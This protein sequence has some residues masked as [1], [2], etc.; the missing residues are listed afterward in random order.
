MGGAEISEVE[1]EDFDENLAP[2]TARERRSRASFWATFESK[3]GVWQEVIIP[4]D[5]FWPN[6]RGR[7]LDYRPIEASKIREVGLMIYDG[8]DGPF[9]FD[10]KKI[11]II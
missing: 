8:D 11:E 3:N 7:R 5:S 2:A 6:W 1:D 10:V 4:L 9:A